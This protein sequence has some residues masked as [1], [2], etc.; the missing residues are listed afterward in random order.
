[1]C[2]V[3]MARSAV[4]K[5]DLISAV[6]VAFQRREILIPKHL[7]YAPELVEELEGFQQQ[8]TAAGNLVYRK[9]SV[10]YDDMI[11]SLALALRAGRRG[12]R[13]GPPVDEN[14]VYDG[15]GR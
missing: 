5:N 6:E 1:M 7:S 10:A 12:E 8:E 9:K 3:S 14:L 2:N 15:K 4:P 11:I 13:T